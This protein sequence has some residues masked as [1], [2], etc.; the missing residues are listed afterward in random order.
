MFL[1]KVNQR[2]VVSD[3][4]FIQQKQS[5]NNVTVMEP[6]TYKKSFIQESIAH[7]EAKSPA[8]KEGMEMLPTYFS[9]QEKIC[10]YSSWV[11]TINYYLKC[12]MSTFLSWFDL[13]LSGSIFNLNKGVSF[14]PSFPLRE[15]A[16]S[17]C[18]FTL[19]FSWVIQG[20]FQLWS[21]SAPRIKFYIN[22]ESSVFHLAVLDSQ[23][24]IFW[25]TSQLVQKYDL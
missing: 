1:S 2:F 19:S 7:R 12:G 20:Y 23:K 10:S 16:L 24:K 15:Y 21:S 25:S 9:D 18:F 4:K 17:R 8:E 13:Y 5:R 22:L 6:F 14:S 3:I 11:L